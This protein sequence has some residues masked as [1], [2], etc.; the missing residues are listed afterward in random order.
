MDGIYQDLLVLVV[1]LFIILV[2]PVLVIVRRNPTKDLREIIR[3]IATVAILMTAC[4]VVI[5]ATLMSGSES[6]MQFIQTLAT[7]VIGYY[8]GERAGKKTLGE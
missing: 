6:A 4:G 5:H 1:L 7:V 2:L 3:P 8:F